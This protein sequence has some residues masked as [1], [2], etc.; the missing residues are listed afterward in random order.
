[1]IPRAT[2]RLQFHPGF[3]LTDAR[4]IVPYLDALGVSHVYASPLTA[5]RPGSTHGYDVAD[6]TRVNPELGGE[7]ALRALSAALNERRMGLIL[8]IVPNHIGI[9]A[10]T[11]WWTDLLAQGPHSPHAAAF[12]VDWSRHGGRVLLPLLGTPLAQAL[13]AGEIRVAEAPGLPGGFA[14]VAHGAHWLPLRPEDCAGLAKAGPEG[15]VAL[16]PRTGAGLARLEELLSRQ[17]WLLAWWRSGHDLLNWRRFFSITD[18]AGVRVEEEAVFEAVHALPLALYQD[19]VIDGLRVD[20][21]D[22][23]TDPAG[24]CRRLRAALD[25]RAPARPATA[26]PGPAWLVVEKILGPGETLARDWEVDGTTGYDFMDAVSALQH[27]PDGAAPLARAWQAVS[28]RH[29]QFAPEEHRA[30][31]QMLAWEFGAQFGATLDAFERLAAETPETAHL[32][33]GMIERALRSLLETF[34]VYRTYGTG[35]SAPRSD[36][37]IRARARARALPE[38]A[39][40]ETEAIDRVLDWLAGEAPGPSGRAAEAVRR[41]QQLSAPIA[42]KAVEDTAFY[43]HAPLLSRNDVGFDP[44]CFSL[45]VAAF[46]ARMAQM[47]AD[48][49]HTML[50]T[51]THDHKRG[52][53]A[54]A[55]LAVLSAAPQDWIAESAAW[56]ALLGPAAEGV[57]GGDVAMLLQ[58][59]VGAWPAG[60]D[61]AA[62]DTRE[63]FRDR[64]SAWAVKAL[65]EAKLRS[66]WTAPDTAYE[67]RVTALLDHALLGPGGRALRDRVADWMARIEAPAALNA[68]SQTALRLTAP[69]VPDTYQGSETGDF[70]LVDPDNRRPVDFER[71]AARLAEGDS[72][73]QALVHRLLTLRRHRPELF[74]GPWEGLVAEGPAAAHVIGWM[75]GAGDTRLVCASGLRF[76]GPRLPGAAFWDGTMLRLPDSLA[77]ATCTDILGGPATSLA[78]GSL[79]RLFAGQDMPLVLLLTGPQT[80]DLTD[81]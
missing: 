21:V 71:L 49:P 25:D 58:G 55:R 78:R 76:G 47:Q 36:A 51:A 54:R 40:G 69:G 57:D 61:G 43:R 50:A 7:P 56:T 29:A 59:L 60:L 11:P 64:L 79:A 1:M 33:R 77:T 70:S 73:K 6:P 34:P 13:A 38:A 23:L 16:D 48:F 19:G 39:P 63:Q 28:G 53:D 68:L 30:R 2:Y 65:R 10:D 15:L 44:E 66:S 52:E 14:A 17:H 32:T 5:A 12:D 37:A 74:R 67:A 42:A 75:R 81:D 4:R 80:E 18:L 26:L 20:H 22:G 8:D 41:F 27:A 24:Y 45:P 31:R 62:R 3:T 46:H 72:A 9:G 35:D